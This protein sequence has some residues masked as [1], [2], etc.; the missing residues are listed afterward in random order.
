MR[1][2][3]HGVFCWLTLRLSLA[4]H[5]HHRQPRQEILDTTIKHSPGTAKPVVEP[6]V[7]TSTRGSAAM[8][9]AALALTAQ[10][11]VDVQESGDTDTQASRDG[12]DSST[13]GGVEGLVGAEDAVVSA[14]A[15]AAAAADE[16]AAAESHSLT[17]GAMKLVYLLAIQVRRI[18]GSLWVCVFLY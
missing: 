13:V 9:A 8:T 15:A 17:Q 6:R 4:A 14:A 10:S 18:G 2:Q 5:P 16:L 3:V 1:W 7:A 11:S 12:A